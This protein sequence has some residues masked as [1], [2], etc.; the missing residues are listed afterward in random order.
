MTTQPLMGSASGAVR[1][2]AT[3][4]IIMRLVAVV[5]TTLTALVLIREALIY[6]PK[7]RLSTAS[8]EE[9]GDHGI[10]PRACI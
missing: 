8:L 2:Y 9:E 5:D 10:P 3:I 4:N 7:R 6:G 1:N